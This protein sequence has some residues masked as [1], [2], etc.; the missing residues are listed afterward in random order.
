MFIYQRGGYLFGNCEQFLV[1]ILICYLSDK[2]KGRVDRVYAKILLLFERGPELF[3]VRRGKLQ[4]SQSDL[5]VGQFHVQ[6]ITLNKSN[7]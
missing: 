5:D 1:M 3:G 4:E 2:G 7:T 6:L